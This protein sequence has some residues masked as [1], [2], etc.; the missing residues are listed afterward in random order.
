MGS[1]GEAQVVACHLDTCASAP[2][3]GPAAPGYGSALAF[4]GGGDVNGS[5]VTRADGSLQLVVN[6]FVAGQGDRY[7]LTV[8]DATGTQVASLDVT[9]TF[10]VASV[11]S[12]ACPMCFT[13]QLGDPA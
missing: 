1:G 4:P 12:G 5:L 11:S 6:W 10:P 8:T 7:T 2:L 13:L 9:A 3:P